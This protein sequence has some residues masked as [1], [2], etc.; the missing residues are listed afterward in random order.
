[1][2][3]KKAKL[4][5]L[6]ESAITKKY[7]GSGIAISV[8]KEVDLWLPSRFLALN[9]QWGGGL[10]YGKIVEIYGEESSGKSLLALDFAYCAQQLGG[11][12]IWIDAEKVFM[13]N[14]SEKNGLDLNQVHLYPEN[15]VELISD[16]IMD[17]VLY[18]RSKLTNNEPILL[19]LDSLAALTCYDNLNT[20]QLDRKAEMGNRAKAIGTMLRDRNAI[21]TDCGVCTILINQLRDKI[22]A[23]N[24]EDPDT[25]PGGAATKFYASI[26]VGVYGG[27]QIKGKI[28]GKETRVG[29]VSSIRIKKNKVAPPRDTLKGVEVYFNT[30]YTKQPIGF[31]KYFG[32]DELII[33]KAVLE[34]RGNRFFLRD[35]LVANGRESLNKVIVDNDDL[36]AKIIRKL[37]V[38]SIS[39]LRKKLSTMNTN[40]YPIKLGKNESED[41]E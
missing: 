20:P 19:V 6:S 11:I 25:T 40:L 1:M 13:K 16:F 8:L 29:R 12:V 3:K 35:K 14:W 33:D 31:N 37:E 22:G 27:K 21:L 23:S 24:Y 41:G 5:L 26:R 18:W 30:E 9:Y 34:K 38:N 15:V 28:R 39:G 2:A 17:S 32:L 10:P 7:S 4:K 36:R